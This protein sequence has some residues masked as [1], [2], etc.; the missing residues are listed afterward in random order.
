MEPTTS[1][2]D[3]STLT[4]QVAVTVLIADDKEFWRLWLKEELEKLVPNLERIMVVETAAEA[5][6]RASSEKPRLIFL[7]IDFRKELKD[8][9]AAAEEIWKQNP[10]ASIIIFSNHAE[11][12]FVKRLYRVTPETGAYGYVL[13]DNAKSNLAHAING[14]LAGDCWIDPEVARVVS[15]IHRQDNNISEGEYEALIC[16]A[17]GYTDST[18]GKVLHVTE[19]A[20]QARLRSLYAKFGIPAKDHEDAGVLSPRCR[21]VWLAGQRGL[22][23]DADVKKWSEKFASI[24][25]TAGISLDLR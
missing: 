5:V 19:R 21:A 4:G 11:E 22:L 3:S 14:V 18:A 10:N 20:V 1:T 15:R 25:K 8:G 16:I 24:G 17:L 6:V 2:F 23:T 7:D 12:A 9:I 13:K